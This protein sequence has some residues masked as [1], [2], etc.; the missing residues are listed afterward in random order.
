MKQKI[1]KHNLPKKTGRPRTESIDPHKAADAMA[2]VAS[3]GSVRA[4]S[5]AVK[6]SAK[7]ERYAL[8]REMGRRFN[9]I[10]LLNFKG[11]TAAARIEAPGG[12]SH[13]A[14]MEALGES[15][16][17]M[18]FDGLVRAKKERFGEK[19]LSARSIDDLFKAVVELDRLRDLMAKAVERAVE[20]PRIW[21]QPGEPDPPKTSTT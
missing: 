3:T 5:R 17:A 15:T 18:M 14:E 6:T 13:A 10:V 1:S 2:V 20:Q 8:Q 19:D 9:E 7:T 11:I 4:A 21:K 16:S 12:W